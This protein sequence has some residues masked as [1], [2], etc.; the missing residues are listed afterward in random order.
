M[1]GGDNGRP[2][3]FDA[4]RLVLVRWRP[5]VRVG[6]EPAPPVFQPDPDGVPFYAPPEWFK[7][8]MPKQENSDDCPF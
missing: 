8:F 7:P 3:Q 5:L 2:G 1:G 4:L 6:A